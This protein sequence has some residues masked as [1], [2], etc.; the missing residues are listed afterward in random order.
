M[1][2]ATALTAT[3]SSFNVYSSCFFCHISFLL[4]FYPNCFGLTNQ[5]ELLCCK[6]GW[7]IKPNTPLLPVQLKCS[8]LLDWNLSLGIAE[9]GMKQP[10]RLWKHSSQCCFI[11]TQAAVPW[12]DDTPCV[13]AACF[14]VAYPALGCCKSMQEAKNGNGFFSRVPCR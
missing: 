12:D 5:S 7:C 11:I 13:L 14:I 1:S 8:N 2:N 6:W 9:F 4:D 3:P 10:E